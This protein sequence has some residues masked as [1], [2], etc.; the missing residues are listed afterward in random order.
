MDERRNFPGEELKKAAVL[1]L[2]LV[3]GGRI[4]EAYSEYVDM[5][6]VHHNLYFPAGFNALRD[7]MI[8]NHSQFPDKKLTVRHVICE[9]DIVA[10]HSQLILKPGAGMSVVHLFRFSGGRITEMWDCGQPVPE[11]SPNSDG[12][13]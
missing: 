13:F 4:D 9:D 3:V 6:G 5:N 10:V 1:F 12:A 2:Q 7:A 8:E 11:D